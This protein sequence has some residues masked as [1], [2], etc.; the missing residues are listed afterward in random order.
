MQIRQLEDDVAWRIIGRAPQAAEAEDTAVLADYFNLSTPLADLVRTWSASCDH[1]A[2]IQPYFQGAGGAGRADAA[3][4]MGERS[5]RRVEIRCYLVSQ[6]DP[7]AV[8]DPDILV[9]LHGP[10]T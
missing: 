6:G 3:L 10:K 8:P 9:P 1:F 5:S 7:D 4:L 2:R